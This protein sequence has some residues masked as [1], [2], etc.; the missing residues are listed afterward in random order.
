MP[1]LPEVE[2][3]R[4]GLAKKIIGKKIKTVE[5]KF[6]RFIN[7]STKEFQQIVVGATVKDVK[8][9]A[10]S[11]IIELSN[12]W[13][14]LV[15]LKMTGQIILDGQ[16]G[17]GAPH[18]IYSFEGGAQLKHYD[19]RKFGYAK[20]IKTEEV[21]KKLANDQLGPEPLDKNFTLEKFVALLKT[22]PKAK[23][24]PLLM[25]QKFIAGIGNIYAQEIC[26]Y[27][28][29]LPT[30]AIATLTKKEIK[31]LYL[32]MRKILEEAISLSGS[33]VDDAY[34]DLSGKKGSYAPKLK[35]YGREGEKCR[36]CK[37]VVKKIKLG[38]RGTN[39]CSCQK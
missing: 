29:V 20:L 38:G 10:K 23:I 1:E 14:I 12:G 31:D 3:I 27:A 35:V 21:E 2:T 25:D 5:I 8:R 6:P 32:G 15:H 19:F 17:T 26:F 36:R 22:K 7:M 28:R 24:K 16:P 39:F 13:S 11:L 34:V 4:R 33:S 9:R 30:R 18:I 37:G